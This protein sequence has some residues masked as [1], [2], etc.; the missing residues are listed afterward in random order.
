MLTRGGVGRTVQVPRPDLEDT[1]HEHC[2]WLPDSLS[3]TPPSSSRL[4]AFKRPT[5]P[6]CKT[7]AGAPDNRSREIS[8]SDG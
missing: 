3:I 8:G 7:I 6:R 2:R 1:V 4:A 5:N